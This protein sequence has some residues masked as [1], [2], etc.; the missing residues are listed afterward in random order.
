MST[1]KGSLSY[2]PHIVKAVEQILPDLSKLS[3]SPEKIALKRLRLNE[4]ARSL[5]GNKK[6]YAQTA[7]FLLKEAGRKLGD[8]NCS[9]SCKH[10][11]SDHAFVRILERIAGLNVINLKD[12]A[13]VLLE[14]SASDYHI[15]RERGKIITVLERYA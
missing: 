6:A 2:S 8:E 14:E 9:T 15:V 13:L 1:P 3:L 7:I 5:P 4:L 11:L 10:V 12:C